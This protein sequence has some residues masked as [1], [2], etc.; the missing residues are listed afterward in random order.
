MNY[1]EKQQ[2]QED[3]DYIEYENN[4]IEFHD[5]DLNS[6]NNNNNKNKIKPSTKINSDNNL[7]IKKDFI[8]CKCHYQVKQSL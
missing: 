4:D 2:D 6:L 3:D 7:I 8:S 5:D 1:I